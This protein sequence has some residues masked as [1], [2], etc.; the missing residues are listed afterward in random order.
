M[1]IMLQTRMTK[2]YEIL[3]LI[4]KLTKNYKIKTL[5]KEIYFKF[6]TILQIKEK[7]FIKLLEKIKLSIKIYF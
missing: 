4:I 7:M 3:L 1:R 6:R 5:K 2:K